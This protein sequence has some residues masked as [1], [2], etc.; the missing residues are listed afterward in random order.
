MRSR[1]KTGIRGLWQIPEVVTFVC[2]LH[3]R[4]P[5][6]PWF[7]SRVGNSLQVVV[8]CLTATSTTLVGPD[9]D[10]L[11][12]AQDKQTQGDLLS[13]WLRCLNRL[14]AEAGI[15]QA[16]VTEASESLGRYLVEGPVDPT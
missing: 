9:P 11:S 5:E 14:A 4:W 16:T 13:S 10:D 7:L 3:S 15:E 8:F 6:A 1:D 2:D 12:V